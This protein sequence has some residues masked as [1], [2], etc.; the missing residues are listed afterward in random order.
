MTYSQGQPQVGTPVRTTGPKRM[1]PL[2]QR[3]EEHEL[4]GTKVRRITLTNQML[5]IDAQHTHALDLQRAVLP[6]WANATWC[7]RERIWARLHQFCAQRDLPPTALN[8]ILFLE[9]LQIAVTTRLTYTRALQ[10]IY[11]HLSGSNAPL[12]L[13]AK[14]LQAQGGLESQRQMEPLTPY[15][16][17]KLCS[18]LTNSEAMATLLCWKAAARWTEVSELSRENFSRSRLKK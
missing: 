17:I 5:G 7:T 18:R 1:K 9:S 10:T 4:P 11:A 13:Y 12:K 16:L 14:A 8:C 15:L 3:E 6:M 2:S